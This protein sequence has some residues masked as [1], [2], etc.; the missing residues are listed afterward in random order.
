MNLPPPKI[1]QR[2][3]KLH[4]MLGSSSPKEAENARAKLV[5]LLAEHRLSWNDLPEILAAI[6]PGGAAG[7]TTRKASPTSTSAPQV[8]VLSLVLVLVEKYVAVTA[9]ERM[10]LALWC[11]HTYV[12]DRFAITPR[13]ALLSPVRGCGKTTNLRLLELLIEDAFRSDNATP[14]AIY[15]TLDHNPRTTLLLD[16]GDNLGLLRNATLRSL[17]NAGHI[18][19]G[20]F[21]RFVGG[22][23][24]KFRVFAP[25]AIAAIGELP[26]PLMHR[27]IVI[28]MQLAPAAS[29]I[30]RLDDTDPAW[31]ASRNEIRKWEASCSLAS[32]P[33]IPSALRNRAADNWRPLLAIADDL[34]MGKEARDA[35]IALSANRSDEDVAVTLLSDLRKIF[36]ALPL[37]RWG[38]DRAPGAYLVEALLGLEDTLWTE[39]RGVN[40]DRPPRKLTQMQL[41][42]L[43]RP[44]RI[45]PKTIWPAQRR[46]GDRSAR[47]YLRSQFEAAWAS[48]CPEA[49]TPAQSSKII[50]LPRS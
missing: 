46:L 48:Y 21:D 22:W 18:R 50:G 44:F 42:Q 20:A 38:E 34:G 17:F 25:L 40:D 19:G 47:G 9:D 3:A 6:K 35:A 49:D 26:L 14:A 27:A 5:K 10:A 39:W 41:A 24:R 1:C 12:F 30:E 23:P 33:E 15:Y 29:Q 28:N 16:E 2:I 4:A 43:L 11:L 31:V 45:R 32:D 7:T 8:N 36:D 37:S 13:L